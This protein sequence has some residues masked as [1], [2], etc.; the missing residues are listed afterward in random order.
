M[1]YRV[2]IAREARK[3]IARLPKDVADRVLEVIAALADEPRPFGC[4]RL[5]SDVRWRIRVGDY[6]VL[7]LIADT[8]LVVTVVRVAHRK[9]AYRP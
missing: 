5:A 7:Y 1:T 3:Q 8:V 6:R 9:D 2:E 4:V